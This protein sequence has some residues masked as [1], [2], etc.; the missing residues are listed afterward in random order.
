MTKALALPT[1]EEVDAELAKRYL[2][3]F[4]IQAWPLVEPD[5]PLSWN[6]HLDELCAVLEA[7]TR[8][9]IT[10]VVINVPPGT[11]KSL[12]VSIF[13]P[14]WEWAS[15]PGLR[16]LTASYGAHLTIRD[17]LRLRAVVT[18]PW[19]QRHYGL[20][21]SG[22]QNS[23]VRFDTTA[24][25]WRIATS[26]GGVGTGEHPD[27]IVIDDPLTADQA[28]SDAERRTA[29][30]WFDRTISTR[31]VVRD[32]RTV[33]IMQRLHEE[34][35]AGHLLGK[36]GW[37]QVRFPMRFDPK[38]ADPRD[39]RTKAGEL[40]WPEL[41]DETRVRQLE[42][43][44]GPYGCT[45]AES[46]VLMSDLSLRPIS[47]VRVGD[48]V[49]GFAKRVR[50]DD[51]NG[52]FKLHRT[53]VS[54]VHRYIAPVVKLHLDS[55]EMVRCTA[56]HKWFTKDR[57][58]DGDR[59]MY[60]PATVG[61]SR[62]ARVCPARLPIL[63]S[64][65]LR[66][67]GWLSGFFDGEGT[68]ST[69]HKVMGEDAAQISFY[70]GAGRNLP[71][72]EKLERALRHFG[73]PFT[74]SEDER[75]T[76]K[77]APCYGYRTYRLTG[78]RVALHQ[79][80]LHVVQPTKWRE[81]IAKGALIGR[82]VSGRERVLSME[83]DGVET[84]YAL[85]TETGNY[86]VWGLL[87]SNSAGQ[88]QQTPAPEGGGLFQRAWFPIVDSAPVKAKRCRGWDTAGTEGGGDWTVGTKLA[89]ADGIVYVEDVVRGQWGP[90]SVDA[91]FKQTAQLDGRD[92]QQ[93]EERE[94]GASG[95]AVIAARA[96]LLAGYDYGEVAVSGDKVTRAKPF[97]AQCEAGNV[98]LVRGEWNEAY[99]QELERFPMG[100]F[101]DQCDS[102]SAA[103]NAL[104][105]EPERPRGGV[106]GRR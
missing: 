50:D 43:D 6:W 24:G 93:R 17:N 103:Y 76:N 88:L 11:A 54:E 21:L 69:A 39:H 7:V 9:E 19:Y 87:S 5:T 92:C 80:F 61:R 60:L 55:G 97:R 100:A 26:V 89:L 32:V 45:P 105:L 72:C 56:D 81:R 4:I 65:E 23:K 20:R 31:G 82:H 36:G 49:I 53:V 51:R 94:G 44:L 47:D 95:K 71:L 86:V 99:L 83:P 40:L 8:G 64:E 74:V 34:D 2:H 25:G 85:T 22:D 70:Q 1:M 98:R 15:N 42:Y 78:P 77:D 27:R 52:R 41:F 30:D 66:L 68:V 29:S 106:W 58:R 62:L 46:P 79:R 101:D 102:T 75:K 28:R 35:L 67:A 90:G 37:E 3:D 12:T 73:F 91:I 38:H 33:V 57:R 84:V 59:P 18:S 10:R 48:E 104:A 96:R 63:S 14:A 16:Y 13:W